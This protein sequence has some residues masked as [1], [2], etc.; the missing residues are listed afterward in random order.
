MIKNNY[1]KYENSNDEKERKSLIKTFED[2]FNN[3]SKFVKSNYKT[4]RHRDI[5]YA[6][7]VLS[8]KK[9]LN[10]N[11]ILEYKNLDLLNTLITSEDA[12][13]RK[14][15]YITIGNSQNEKL[16][17]F[18]ISAIKTE[19]TFFAIPSLIL[20]LGNF[21]NSL[22]IINEFKSNLNLDDC[23]EKI[24][25]EIELTFFKAIDKQSEHN[26]LS[27]KGFNKNLNFL[28][29]TQKNLKECLRT[30]IG[31]NL[32]QKEIDE[33][34]I[35]STPDINSIFKFRCF[36]KCLIFNENLYKINKN[37]QEISKNLINLIK[38]IDFLSIFDNFSK[39]NYRIS[40]NVKNNEISKFI[41]STISENFSYMQNSPSK[42]DIE[43]ILE[44]VNDKL[45]IFINP[46]F[47]KDTRFN[48]R[49]EDLPASINP[50]TSA[51]VNKFTTKYIKNPANVLDPFCGTSTM[52]IEHSFINR[53]ATL[54]G[55]DISKFAT[56][57]SFKNA[58]SLNIKLNLTHSDILKFNSDIKFDLIV[59]NLP[60]GTRVGN[61]KNN[62]AL[63]ENFVKLLPQFLSKNSYAFLYSTEVKLLT[64]LITANKNLTLIKKHTL[65]SGNM[66][67]SLFIVKNSS[68]KHKINIK[69]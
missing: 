20:A 34:I 56:E 51:I 27:F 31:N 69:K 37:Y 61:H 41:Y 1:L 42:Y 68:K 11:T 59:S 57:K 9:S 45:S 49:I 25:T 15:T 54:Y 24:K 6:L 36:Y 44:E 48:Y 50:V 5:S 66:N 65:E 23:P 29:T 55:V 12:K 16:K 46:T 17:P 22:E 10:I 62:L 3:F 38:N 14:N 47:Y 8:K 60:F 19:T 35:V 4:L 30:E 2:D 26:E 7:S 67:P 53:N 43:I 52:L 13:T 18:L 21:K 58:N 39:I 28:L 32:S 33:G 63:Y 40:S 64:K